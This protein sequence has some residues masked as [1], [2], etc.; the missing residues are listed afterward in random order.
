MKSFKR[1]DYFLKHR[2]ICES[3]D[4]CNSLEVPS[5]LQVY[6]T[7]NANTDADFNIE[8]SENY[9]ASLEVYTTYNANTDADFNIETSENYLASLEV[10]MNNSETEATT[11]LLEV[12]PEI[13]S[14]HLPCSSTVIRDS[15]YFANYREAK[16]KITTMEEIAC[17]LKSPVQKQVKIKRNLSKSSILTDILIHNDCDTIQETEVVNSLI[18]YLK[19]LNKNKEFPLFHSM[20]EKIFSEKLDSSIEFSYW[21]A[22]RLDIRP[23]RFI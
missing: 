23:S 20:I 10:N 3:I 6:T 5:L 2:E 18:E 12:T 4:S 15:S 21:L 7:Y 11:E 9:L 8:T 1:N 16:R 13:G 17:R 22:S 14:I 19:K